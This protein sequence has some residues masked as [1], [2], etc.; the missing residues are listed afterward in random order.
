MKSDFLI[1]FLRVRKFDLYRSV[2][3]V[4]CLSSTRC[5]RLVNNIS[6]NKSE[7]SWRIIW[8]W[9][10]VIHLWWLLCALAALT[11]SWIWN[12]NSSVQKETKRADTSWF[13]EQ[14]RSFI[15]RSLQ[16]SSAGSSFSFIFYFFSHKARGIR[17]I[18]PS[19][20]CFGW[21][22]T[23]WGDWLARLALNS[24]ESSLCSTLT[25]SDGTRPDISR[26]Q[27]PSSWLIYSRFNFFNETYI[28]NYFASRTDT[29]KM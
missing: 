15:V 3:L 17:L 5:T 23:A 20:I 12:L 27:W 16:M 2:K 9:T 10:T 21:T 22:F 13:V 14:V 25:S 29:R 11:S 18:V 19:R 26:R 28:I 1:I 8:K 24:K 7:C 4:N 6:L